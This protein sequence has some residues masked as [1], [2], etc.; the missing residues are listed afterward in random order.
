MDTRGAM[1][2]VATADRKVDSS[3]DTE[4]NASFRMVRICL[5]RDV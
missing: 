1:M 2:V 3:E 4:I 5:Q